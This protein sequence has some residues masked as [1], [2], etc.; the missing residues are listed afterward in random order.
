MAELVLQGVSKMF[1]GSVIAVQDLNLEVRDQ[2]LVVLVGPSGCGKTTTLRLIAGLER[3]DQG[4]IWIDG[5]PV[6]RVAPRDR[7][8]AM[9]FQHSVLYPHMTVFKNMAVG[10]TWRGDGDRIRRGWMRWRQPAAAERRAAQRRAIARQVQEAARVL[11]IEHLLE[12]WPRQLSGGEC[13]R[14]ALGRAIVRQPAAFLLDEPLSHLDAR[15]RVEMRREIRRLRQRVR[16]CLVY[17]THDQAEALA[18][19]D[20]VVVMH[21]GRIQQTGPPRE[22]Y[23]QPANVFVAGFLGAPG[24]NL[25]PGRWMDTGDRPCFA[26]G[27]LRV[28]LP[29]SVWGCRPAREDGGVTLGIRP[30]H[31]WL[32]VRNEVRN[33]GSGRAG[34]DRTAQVVGSGRVVM[35][36]LCGPMVL[37]TVAVD[38]GLD[39]DGSCRGRTTSGSAQRPEIVVALS[40]GQTVEAGHEVSVGLDSSRIQLFDA[41]TGANLRA[42]RPRDKKPE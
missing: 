1:G 24:M 28:S 17:V 6:N 8:I 38:G 16:G 22:V 2:E 36:E 4:M 40:P 29:A 9:V 25:L 35:T 20:R 11:G 7:N 18:L 10:L 30:E 14:V 23:D 26:S 3:P 41:R 33:D 5:R 21:R 13:Q 27:G 19:G 39:C 42:M 34:V 31:L 32:E 12:R 37:A 15:L